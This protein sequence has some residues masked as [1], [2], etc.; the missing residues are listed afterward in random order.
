MQRIPSFVKES[1]RSMFRVLKSSPLAH[2]RQFG[3]DMATGMRK[4]PS[5]VR[6]SPDG[7]GSR[8]LG[9]RHNNQVAPEP[10]LH[11]A[12]VLNK[13]QINRR[14]DN[15]LMNSKKNGLF[16][17]FSRNVLTFGS[18]SDLLRNS[19]RKNPRTPSKLRNSQAGGGTGRIIG[20]SRLAGPSIST[21]IER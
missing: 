9:S 1:P 3:H 14:V 5:F 21:R 11:K 18:S 20:G 10:S 16:R 7:G 13:T 6:S 19:R 2:P 12:A 15:V 17:S 4:I 8:R